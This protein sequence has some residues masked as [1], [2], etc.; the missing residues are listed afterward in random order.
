MSRRPSARALKRSLLA[1]VCVLAIASATIQ[2]THTTKH[3]DATVR[4][5]PATIFPQPEPPT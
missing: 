2:P 5:V 4:T 3:T 1:A